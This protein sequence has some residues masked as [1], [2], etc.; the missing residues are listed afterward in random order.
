MIFI[1]VT[2]YNVLAFLRRPEEKK[3]GPESKMV[4]GEVHR[5]NRTFRESKML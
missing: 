5:Q 4:R 2:Y 3:T 1:N